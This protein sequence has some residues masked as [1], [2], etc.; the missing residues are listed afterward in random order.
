MS[1]P[2]TQRWSHDRQVVHAVPSPN[3]L[4]VA[5]WIAAIVAVAA[6]IGC[7]WGWLVSGGLFR[8]AEAI[9]EWR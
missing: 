7:G 2:Q 6:L 8:L 3:G 9:G 1:R 5:M 4:G